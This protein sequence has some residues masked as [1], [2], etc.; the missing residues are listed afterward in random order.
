VAFAADL[1]QRP[2]ARVVSIKWEAGPPG[3]AQSTH[4]PDRPRRPG[5]AADPIQRLGARVVSN[6]PLQLS[7]IYPLCRQLICSEGEFANEYGCPVEG[8][9]V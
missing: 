4:G 1:I 9:A 2:G 8:L 5:F 7:E 3:G 6:S